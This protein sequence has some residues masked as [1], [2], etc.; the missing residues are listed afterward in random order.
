MEMVMTYDLV[1]GDRG[2]S[3]WSLRGWLLFDA[4]GIPVRTLTARLYT[5]EL[6][7]LLKD[8]HPAKTAPTMRTPDGV[9]VPESLAIAEEHPLVAARHADPAAGD[10]HI[11]AATAHRDAGVGGHLDG[12]LGHGH[13]ADQAL[14][15]QLGRRNGRATATCAANGHRSCK[16]FNGRCVPRTHRDRGRILRHS[17]GVQLGQHC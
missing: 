8:F 4:F 2:Y 7:N 3:S 16:R 12:G 14:R 1:I 10:S 11:G 5:D 17:H 6:P 9:V 15:V 13:A